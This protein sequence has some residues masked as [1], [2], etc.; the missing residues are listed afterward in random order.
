M[1]HGLPFL[2]IAI[3]IAITV[4]ACGDKRPCITSQGCVLVEQGTN[5]RWYPD[6]TENAP[7]IS[8]NDKDWKVTYK[9]DDDTWRN[10]DISTIRVF[11]DNESA[12]NKI[13]KNGTTNRVQIND[14][15]PP[16]IELCLSGRL[17]VDELKTVWVWLK[18]TLTPTAPANPTLG[19]TPATST[20]LPVPTSSNK[21]ATPQP[22][23]PSATSP[24]GCSLPIEDLSFSPS[25][26][27]VGTTV[28]IHAKAT[29]N[30]CFRAMRLKI[31]GNVVYELGSPEF[32]YSWNTSGYSAGNHT[33]RLEVAAQNDNNWA[34]PSV[35]ESTYS[36]QA[37]VTAT[38]PVQPNTTPTPQICQAPPIEDLSFNPSS[39]TVG[40][41]VNVHAKATWNS[42]F[43][44]MRLKIDG[45]IVYELGSPEFT[46][47]WNTSGY[48]AG[49]HT[50][51]LEVAAQGDNSWSSPSVREA[52]FTLQ[53]GAT[54][55][56]IPC[57]APPI[58]DLSF[59]PG[60]PATVGMTVNVHA[61]ATW[62]SC[63]RSMRLKID[64]NIVYELGSPEWNYN[65]NTS[66]YSTGNH[67]IRLEVAAQ[68]DNSWSNP[69]VREVTYTLQAG[70]TPT[71][72]PCTAPPI[73]DLSFNPGS[74]ATVGTTVNVH[75]KATWNSCF[76]S[77]RL[78]IDGNIVYELG[79][80]EW[81]YSWNTSGYSVGGHTIRLEVAAQGDNSWSNPS[82]REETYTLQSAGGL[83]KPT[84]ISP[85]N[86]ALLPPGTDVTLQWNSVSGATQYLVEIWGGQYGGTHATPCGWQSGT[87]CHIGT[88]SP[89]NVLWRVQARDGAGNLSPWSDEWNFTPQ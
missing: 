20:P 9:T 16:S 18:T 32:T 33:V 46:Y 24:Q 42:C 52:N 19:N 40:T 63:F 28:N 89:G 23:S 70:A 69:S 53:A 14:P 43:R 49:G 29:W 21:T 39:A 84:L 7:C 74:P 58:E 44:A 73:E 26:A 4:V 65:W 61:K 10:A 57:T 36:L 47:S 17:T 62:N 22:I 72:V 64:G 12:L 41:T 27:I 86:G 80:P 34:N 67:T 6:A 25:S 88:M 35:S 54:A 2:A 60:S 50:I 78:K 76:R 77:M 51:R 81:N 59:N 82:V 68:G 15:Q 55:T 48:S 37:G 1:K 31:D 13:T 85:T 71:P 83:S 3:F 66:G 8:Q 5:A 75:A 38:Q 56:P 11:S 45:N 79:S 30:N 87:S